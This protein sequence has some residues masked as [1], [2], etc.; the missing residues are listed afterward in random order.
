MVP[1]ISSVSGD[2]SRSESGG[3]VLSDAKS[4][5]SLKPKN[6]VNS[7][8]AERKPRRRTVLTIQ[9]PFFMYEMVSL[10]M[11]PLVVSWLR[12]QSQLEYQID[13]EATYRGQLRVTTSHDPRNSL[14]SSIRRA[15]TAFSASAGRDW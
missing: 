12:S 8:T 9:A 5:S 1:D 13:A 6:H 2:V 10:L 7:R 15:L 4:S 11:M 14:R 3:D